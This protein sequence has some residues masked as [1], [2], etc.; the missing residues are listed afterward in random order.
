MQDTEGMKYDQ[1]KP[2]MDLIPPDI[3][4]QVA[5]VLTFGAMKYSPDNWRKVPDLERRY[6]AAALRHINAIKRGEEID[7]ESGKTHAAHAICCLMFL[8]QVQ[9][10]GFKKVPTIEEIIR[11]K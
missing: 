2:M 1:D 10:E 6:I 7:G 8:G 11:G 4:L 9:L 5:E 3:E